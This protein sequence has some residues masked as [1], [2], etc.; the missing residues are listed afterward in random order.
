MQ[1]EGKINITLDKFPEEMSFLQVCEALNLTKHALNKKLARGVVTIPFARVRRER[2][3]LR[4][5]VSAYL[6]HKYEEAREEANK[7]LKK[8]S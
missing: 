7:R 3:A 5:D 6:K 2:T 4:V 8:A 1:Y